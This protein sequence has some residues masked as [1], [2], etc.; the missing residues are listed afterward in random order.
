MLRSTSSAWLCALFVLGA[1]ALAGCP[2]AA[3]EGCRDV[4]DCA[5]DEACFFDDPSSDTGECRPDDDDDEPEPEPGAQPQPEP[6]PEPE[7]E[8]EP[9][10]DDAGVDG[11]V[12]PPDDA[13]FDAGMGAPDAGVDAGGPLVDGGPIDAGVV[14]DA[15]PTDGGVV[16]AGPLRLTPLGPLG[17]AAVLHNDTHRGWVLVAPMPHPTLQSPTYQLTLLPR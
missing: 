6:A 13:G 15:G 17:G 14:V 1:T 8:P 5:V 12:T 4:N 2:P 10:V 11:G 3:P 16:P 7:P 9:I